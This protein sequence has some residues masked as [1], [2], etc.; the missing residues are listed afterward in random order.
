MSKATQKPASS[1]TVLRSPQNG[2]DLFLQI[3]YSRDDKLLR[4][5]ATVD[6]AREVML[7]IA[8][9]Q[10][11]EKEWP[12]KSTSRLLW[13]FVA[14]VRELKGSP[15]CSP[16]PELMVWELMGAARTL[17]RRSRKKFQELAC[18]AD[19]IEDWLTAT[20]C[21]KDARARSRFFE[22]LGLHDR[23]SESAVRMNALGAMLMDQL[24]AE[25]R[26]GVFA[27]GTS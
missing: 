20:S 25:T 24:L 26:E 1:R 11:E 5:E 8:N 17:I 15:N 14:R 22:F 3:Y 18:Y 19:A 23:D 9:G 4:L 6:L 10:V 21:T 27:S 13:Y 7:A 16:S 12:E 2:A